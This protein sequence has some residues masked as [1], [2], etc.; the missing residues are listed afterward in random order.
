M[1]GCTWVDIG[2]ASHRVTITRGEAT[3]P[4]LESGPNPLMHHYSG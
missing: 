4:S 2:L 3:L 1:T